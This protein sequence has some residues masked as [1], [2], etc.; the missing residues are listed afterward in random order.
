ML[1][2]AEKMKEWLEGFSEREYISGTT[3][4]VVR[5]GV[6]VCVKRKLC[7]VNGLAFKR[8]GFKNADFG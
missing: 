2:E 8:D 1:S 6:E 5:G 7:E 3:N 4:N